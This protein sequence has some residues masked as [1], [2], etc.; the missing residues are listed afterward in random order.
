[1]LEISGKVIALLD[2]KEGVSKTTGNH[3]ML[4][5]FVIETQ[6][7]HP[8]KALMDVFGEDKIKQYDLHCGDSVKVS[9]SINS[10]EYN[11]RWYNSFSLLNLVKG[12]TQQPDFVPNAPV[13]DLD[14]IFGKEAGEED[15]P[16]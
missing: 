2:L 5:Q 16:F 9:F 12:S 14:A 10:K 4:Q 13:D 15:P 3:W 1:M 7:E 8:K 11:G 6:E